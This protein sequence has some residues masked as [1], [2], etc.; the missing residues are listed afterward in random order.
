MRN[1]NESGSGRREW[2]IAEHVCAL[3]DVD[4]ERHLGHILKTDRWH[5]YDATHFDPATSGIAYLGAFDALE[6][7]R[8]RVETAVG[9]A[10]RPMVSRAGAGS[11]ITAYM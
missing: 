3:V 1:T 2:R 10:P 8:L 4:D 7:A 9:G 5:A 11:F 6:K